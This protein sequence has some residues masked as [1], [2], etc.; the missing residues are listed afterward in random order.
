VIGSD[1]GA[2][3]GL[4]GYGLYVW[5]AILVT[6]GALVAEIVLLVLRRRNILDHL[7]GSRRRLKRE[8]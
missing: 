2:F 7:G 3:I 1:W 5:G 8:A 4:G 6:I